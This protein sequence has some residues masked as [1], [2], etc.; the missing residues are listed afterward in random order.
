MGRSLTTIPVGNRHTVSPAR[1]DTFRAM[2]THSRGLP[3][4]RTHTLTIHPWPARGGQALVC[5]LVSV[6]GKASFHSHWGRWWCVSVCVCGQ[7]CSSL[8]LWV[9]HLC[10]CECGCMTVTPL[11]ELNL[12]LLTAPYAMWW[13]DCFKKEL[14]FF[15]SFWICSFFLSYSLCS[16][17]SPNTPHL[18]FTFQH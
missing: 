7:S 6:F 5:V 11:V 12:F 16:S 1:S 17:V 4:T 2:Q 14:L 15:S 13:M 10:V 9:G 18:C 8:C 3:D